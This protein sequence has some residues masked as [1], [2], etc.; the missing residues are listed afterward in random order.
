MLPELEG[1]PISPE[2]VKPKSGQCPKNLSGKR[3][4]ASPRQTE[5]VEIDG[6]E[7]Y[8]RHEPDGPDGDIHEQ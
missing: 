6:R 8:T 2:A 5:A 4:D 1:N 7:E 3:Q